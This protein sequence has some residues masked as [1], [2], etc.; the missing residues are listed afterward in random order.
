MRVV[1]DEEHFEEDELERNSIVRF[2]QRRTETRYETLETG[3]ADMVEEELSAAEGMQSPK[4]NFADVL[5]ELHR[6][7]AEKDADK[8][9]T[10][11]QTIPTS[12]M[13][14][15]LGANEQVVTDGKLEGQSPNFYHHLSGTY[16]K[17]ME[18]KPRYPVNDSLETKMSQNHIHTHPS[19]TA[20]YWR[21]VSVHIDAGQNDTP[22]DHNDTPVDQSDAPRSE[23]YWRY[24]VAILDTD[25]ATITTLP[26]DSHGPDR[27]VPTPFSSW[28]AER[29]F[30]IKL[31]LFIFAVA[32]GLQ[33][34]MLGVVKYP[35]PSSDG[36]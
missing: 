19:Q 15:R 7:R 10:A 2:L 9:F 36:S 23:T 16:W 29:S 5:R 14:R 20:P 4:S 34:H 18:R 8:R 17:Q 26:G 24:V 35:Y 33:L 13:K 32:V 31:D 27:A 11:K 22:V 1:D 21:R 25:P 30:I 12:D 6:R 28:W 3:W